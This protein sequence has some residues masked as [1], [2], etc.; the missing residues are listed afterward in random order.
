MNLTHISWRVDRY[1]QFYQM[2]EY[3]KVKPISDHMATYNG[4]TYLTQNDLKY[5]PSHVW[6][7]EIK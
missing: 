6:L 1:H 5:F 7:Y 3:S 4:K 2:V